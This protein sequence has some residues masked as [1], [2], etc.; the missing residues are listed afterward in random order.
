MTSVLARFIHYARIDTRSDPGNLTPPSSPNQLR[1]AH[2]LMAELRELGLSDVNLDE[3]G[4]VT[5][6]LPGNLSSTDAPTIGLIAH[7]D[8]S[9]DFPGDGVKPQVI[10]H[11][12]GGDIP[13]R[14]APGQV[15]SPRDFP[16]LLDYRGQTLVT[17]DGT[18]LLGADDKA[19]IA[20]I[21]AALEEL[22]S[23]PEI[24]RVPLKIA[25]TPDEETG[26]GAP[27]F[28]VEKFGADFAFTVDG[29]RIGEINFENF[30]AAIARVSIKGR[31]VHPGSAKDRMINALQVAVEFHNNLPAEE[32]PEFT[33]G[34]EGFYHLT[35]LN[36]TVEEAGMDYI[37]RDHDQASFDRRKQLLASLAADL[38]RKYGPGS[39]EID[40]RD[41]YFNM[42]ECILPVKH[43]IDTAVTAMRGLGAEPLLIPVR[44]GTDGAQ[45]SFRGLPTPNLFT[46][47]HNFHGRYEFIPVESMEKAVQ[48]L[49]RIIGLY[50]EKHYCGA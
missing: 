32:R 50:A 21:M 38:N 11:Y 49:I 30:N 2:V 5:A 18:T 36:G 3:H 47:G 17:T 4:F 45:F 12:D 34:Y 15:L 39:V 20:E 48:V 9:P 35:A 1:L 6:F 46:G 14:G 23:H 28:D 16:E 40:L 37:L 22:T 27:L 24:P 41:Q 13:L 10:E 44:G 19:G 25:F 33:E 42:K 31:S 43:I 29:G 8:T 26:R 7:M